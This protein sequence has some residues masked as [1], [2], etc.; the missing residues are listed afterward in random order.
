[1]TGDPASGRS[2][3][4]ADRAA[5]GSSVADDAASASDRS[6]GGGEPSDRPETDP[7]ADPRRD[8]GIKGTLPDDV[9]VALPADVTTSEAAAIVAAIGAHVRDLEAAAAAAAE[10]DS[11]EQWRDRKWRFA[12]R[13]ASV[14][15]RG[16]SVPDGAPTDPWTASGRADRF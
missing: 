10:E 4:D 15:G 5:E 6:G 11:E 13:L 3:T 2:A 8:G 9:S 12:G 7:A 16:A 1:M 14:R